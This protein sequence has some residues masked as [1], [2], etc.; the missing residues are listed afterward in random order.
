MLTIVKLQQL[1]SYA[2]LNQHVTE[3]NGIQ[4]VTHLNMNQFWFQ[5]EIPPSSFFLVMSN[6]H[7]LYLQS[8]Y[9]S[10]AHSDYHGLDIYIVHSQRHIRHN[11]ANQ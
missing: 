7:T 9:P 4:D 10:F 2:I 8:H 3:E 11:G 5:P 1:C 6:F